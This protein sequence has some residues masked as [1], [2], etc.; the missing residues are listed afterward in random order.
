MVDQYFRYVD[1]LVPYHIR[2]PLDP[3]F[4]IHMGKMDDDGHIFPVCDRKLA[5]E[6]RTL[7]FRDIVQPD[8]SER[9]TAGMIQI[10]FDPVDHFIR[11]H[12]IF[13]LF[14]V[15]RNR[16]VMINAETAR[17]DRLEL[18]NQLKIIEERSCVTAVASHPERGLDTGADARPEHCLIVIGRSGIHMDMRLNDHGS[19]LF[20]RG[21]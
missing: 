3:F 20:L 12:S 15:Q 17:A 11:Q 4:L 10:R 19:L 1:A 7:V 21:E 2:S 16:G 5:L 14:R 6:C 18:Q 9:D 13:R 8:L